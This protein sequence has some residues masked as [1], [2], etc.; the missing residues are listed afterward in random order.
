M[1]A[2]TVADRALNLAE[3]LR[4]ENLALKARLA[5]L[6]AP[7]GALAEGVGLGLPTCAPSLAAP[8]IGGKKCAKRRCKNPVVQSGKPGRPF[9]F[10]L[11]HR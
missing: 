6:E 3:R 5:K 8:P 1:E 4:Q 10:C 9:K 7:I 11:E 2:T